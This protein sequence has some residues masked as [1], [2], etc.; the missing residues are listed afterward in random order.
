[1][2]IETEVKFRMDRMT[3]EEIEDAY[4]RTRTVDHVEDQTNQYYDTINGEIGQRK[5][6]LRL[7]ILNTENRSVLAIKQDTADPNKRLEIEEKYEGL[8]ETLP[9]DSPALKQ[10]LQDIGCTYDDI[11]PLVMLRTVRTIYMLEEDDLR[12]EVCF[13][14]V[15]I[16]DVCREHKLYEIEFE[17]L[18]GSEEKLMSIVSEFKN[19]YGDR[20]EHSAVSKLAYALKLVSC[21]E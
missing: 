20:V 18:E 21:V 15:S 17:L 8:L 11:V 19:Q 13:D 4:N 6:G 16:V 7:R 12:A 14:D 5:I 10:L 9:E 3:W 2:A 1:M